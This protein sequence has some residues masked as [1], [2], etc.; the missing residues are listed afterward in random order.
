MAK[1]LKRKMLLEIGN[2]A[3][4]VALKIVTYIQR[5]GEEEDGEDM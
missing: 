5:K 4:V 3:L 1:K 2:A